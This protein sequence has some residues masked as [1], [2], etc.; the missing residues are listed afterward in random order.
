VATRRRRALWLTLAVLVAIGA[1][2]A[3]LAL[4]VYDV[5]LFKSGTA[6]E[7][8]PNLGPGARVLVNRLRTPR[9]G[10]VVVLERKEGG[11]HMSRVV[12][13][14]GDRVAFVDSRPYVDGVKVEWDQVGYTIV[15]QRENLVFRETLGARNYLVLDDVNRRMQAMFSRPVSGYWVLEDNREYLLGKDSRSL[16]EISRAQIRGVVTWVL[17]TGDLPYV[18]PTQSTPADAGVSE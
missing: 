7:M 11:Y 15:D 3:V 17:A 14:P 6:I 1:L 8:L 12:A 9:R 18:R 4:F 16:G 2:W 13:V 10:D 5:I